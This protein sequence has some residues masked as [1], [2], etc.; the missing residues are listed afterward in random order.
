MKLGDFVCFRLNP[1]SHKIL[2]QSNTVKSVFSFPGGGQG[3]ENWH[4]PGMGGFNLK[5]SNWNRGSKAGRS[6]LSYSSGLR[7][8]K[9]MKNHSWDPTIAADSR[10][11][12]AAKE[13]PA[14]EDSFYRVDQIAARLAL[15]NR[16]ANGLIVKV[17]DQ[18]VG[19]V[20]REE[21][22]RDIGIECRY[23]TGRLDTVHG[24]HGNVEDDDI[25]VVLDGSFDRFLA[26]VGLGTHLPGGSNL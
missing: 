21:N 16:A 2:W 25:G 14:V 11:F 13:R 18:F 10:G 15:A 23:V 19:K 20:Q 7:W 3:S 6:S 12:P 17:V 8:A 4:H 1:V 5:P 22:D 24:R 9:P 26:I